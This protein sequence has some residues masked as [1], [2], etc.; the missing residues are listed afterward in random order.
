MSENFHAVHVSLTFRNLEATDAIK[1]YASEKI[2]HCLE[3]FVHKET[4]AHVVLRVE[5]NRQIAEATF[6][7]NGTAFNGKEESLDLYSAIDALVDS[8]GRQLR[9][10]KEK[11]TKHH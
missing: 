3:K 7:L 5:R 9:K 4:E 8:L 11:L 2:T 6:N 1:Q 10:H